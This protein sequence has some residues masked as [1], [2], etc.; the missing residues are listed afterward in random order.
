M[1]FRRAAKATRAEE[2]KSCF[3]LA[4]RVDSRE[5]AT[6]RLFRDPVGMEILTNVAERLR[7]AGFRMTAP[8]PR[9]ACDAAFR[10]RF[11]DHLDIGVTLIAERESGVVGC[12]VL[13]NCSVRAWSR[14]SPQL[15]RSRW[16]SVCVAV[17]EALSADSKVQSL[18]SLTRKELPEGERAELLA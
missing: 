12:T 8:K 17:E 9:K 15:A 14:V 6:F 4:V 7:I 18:R 11:E 1:M 13:T 16:M 5:S 10:V 2:I 3:V